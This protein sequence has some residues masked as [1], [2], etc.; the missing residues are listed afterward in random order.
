MARDLP[1]HD[2]GNDGI[3]LVFDQQIR[4]EPG[5]T[6]TYSD[7]A[8]RIASPEL[9]TALGTLQAEWMPDKGDMK[10]HRVEIRRDG[11]IIDL[12]GEGARFEVLRREQRLEQR[13]LSGALTATMS[14][15]GI[16]V[17]DVIRLST[18]APSRIRCWVKKYRQPPCCC[19]L[20]RRSRKGGSALLGLPAWKSSWARSAQN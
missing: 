10:V 2:T 20:P 6:S 7:I 5:K 18:T 14:L 16:R 13:T 1:T 3:I 19:L 9:L 8:Y 11:K 17:G 12:I 4:F 15:P